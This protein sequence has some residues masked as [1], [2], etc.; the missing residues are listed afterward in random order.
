LFVFE[1]EWNASALVLLRKPIV[2]YLAGTL[3]IAA[4]SL[5]L[6][7][8]H[9]GTQLLTAAN[10]ILVVI[11]LVAITWGMPQAFLASVLGALCLNYFFVSP[12][13]TLD[14]HIDGSADEIAFVTFLFTAI[15]VGK[16][17]SR[18]QERARENQHLYEQLRITFNRASQMEA[19]KQTERFKTA[20]LDS[21]T[22]DL[23]TPLTS[24]KAAA[25][26][27]V[28]VR[29]DHSE[30][31]LPPGS[32]EDTLLNIIVK[33]SSRLNHFFEGMIEL[34]KIE[35]TQPIEDQE[36]QPIPFDE[37]IAAALA[38]AEDVLRRH[39]VR[40]EC[41]EHL[42]TAVS[43]KALTQVLFSL[44][45]NSGKYAPPGTMVRV[46]ARPV[47]SGEIW[48]AVEDEGPGVALH[49]REKVFEKFFR[50]EVTEKSPTRETGLGLGLAIAHGIVEAH[51]GRIWI[52]DVR[53]G[54]P[55]ARFVFTIPAC[56]NGRASQVQQAA[57]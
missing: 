34:A 20:L 40:V 3:G 9:L 31:A 37:I 50:G 38:R 55:G 46:V 36:E 35:S 19:I 30:R 14:L 29:R 4:I 8:F 21:V 57:S 32:S 11:L 13:G 15:I 33:E 28:A 6:S 18:A 54:R 23:R 10:M 17:S 2:G 16:L 7:P 26:T 39:E 12:A 51:G 43:P 47:G 53:Q 48:I 52:E 5:I 25:D 24:I 44:L 41:E 1:P 22:H 49:L 42:S 45:E 27:L 56:Q